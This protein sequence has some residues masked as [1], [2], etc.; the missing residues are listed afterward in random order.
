MNRTLGYA[1]V[2]VLAVFLIGE[3]VAR[4]VLGLGTPPLSIAHNKIEY[5]FAPDQ[6]VQRFGNRQLYNEF[7]M[8]SSPLADWGKKRRV[9][10]FGDS[11]VNG[12][13]LT[14][15]A[16]L[17]TTI[18]SARVEGSVFANISAGSWGPANIL[19]YVET[20]GLFN[21]DT[22]ILVLSSHD[23]ADPPTFLALD[24]NTNPTEQPFSAL[25]EGFTRY[26]PRYLPNALRGLLFSDGASRSTDASQQQGMDGVD[27]LPIL[28]DLIV[29]NDV[30]VC[31]VLH[32]SRSE[33]RDGNNAF[34]PFETALKNFEAPII[35]MRDLLTGESSVDKVFRDDIHISA[36]GQIVLAEALVKCDAQARSLS[37]TLS[38]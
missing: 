4:Y 11:V 26:L 25:G 30:E 27:A 38:Q 23:A 22:V 28:L 9:L 18:A 3:L 2:M 14:D 36:A 8:R 7:G 5:M 15:H 21:A 1:V 37:S 20:F 12:G 34:E 35:Y 33:L 10:V 24:P 32:S 6:D 13:N 29:R 16:Q 17:G 31:I 19:G